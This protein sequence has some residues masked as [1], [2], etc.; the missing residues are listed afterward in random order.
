M[1]HPTHLVSRS[2]VLVSLFAGGWASAQPRDAAPDDTAPPGAAPEAPAAAVP[3]AGFAPSAAPSAAPRPAPSA[4]PAPVV[5]SNCRVSPHASV[6]VGTA[7]TIGGLVCDQLRKHEPS[8]GQVSLGSAP[9]A[10][11]YDIQVQ[12]LGQ[13]VLLKLSRTSDSGALER[14]EAVT[15]GAVEEATE[16]APRLAAAMWSE[17]PFDDTA[18]VD[19]LVGD[20]TRRYKKKRGESLF[21]FGLAAQTVGSEYGGTGVH[22]TYQYET[23]SIAL[24]IRAG[25]A[26]L[27]DTDTEWDFQSLSIGGRY[28]FNEQ[29]I[30]PFVGAGLGISHLAS[31]DRDDYYS[32]ASPD[33]EGN[34]SGGGAGAY[35]EIGVEMLR[36]HR[37]RLELSLRA[38]ILFYSM[39]SEDYS[40][41]DS[42]T[43]SSQRVPGGE[44]KYAVPVSLNATLFF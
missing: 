3:S 4:A 1:L 19:N 29:N 5:L 44:S 20:E 31:S 16:A 39:Q 6:D 13:K 26:G 25:A 28:F 27:G 43:G 33:A 18:Q 32:D 9:N 42:S 10:P 37:T 14:T 22:F 41:Y 36:L 23:P 30:S 24:L 7:L 11:G 40:Y 17:V 2:L 12:R 21:G 38:D 8:V 35:A 34:Y 15:L